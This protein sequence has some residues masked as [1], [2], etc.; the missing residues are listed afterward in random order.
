MDRRAEHTWSRPTEQQ[1]RELRDRIIAKHDAL[2]GSSGG[3]HFGP[4]IDAIIAVLLVGEPEPPQ[5]AK[6]DDGGE[7]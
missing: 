7:A 2:T 4:L 1:A 3:Q 5:T 6:H